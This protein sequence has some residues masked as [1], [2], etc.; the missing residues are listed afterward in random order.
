MHGLVR[1]DLMSRNLFGP[2]FV[3]FVLI[4]IGKTFFVKCDLYIE[5]FCI[6]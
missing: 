6:L 5:Y 4:N 3:D 2:C 1:V